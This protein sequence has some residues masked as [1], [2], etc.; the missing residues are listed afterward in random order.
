[1]KK[2]ISI[3]SIT[4]IILFSACNDDYMDRF[5]E[6][7]IGTENFFKSEEDL[8]MFIY[9][10]YNFAGV[11]NY[12]DDGYLTTDN[13]ANTG[14]TELKN[15][16][17]SS[18]P[19]SATITGGWTWSTLRN[20]NLFLENADKADISEDVLNHYKGVA[21]FFRARFYMDKVKR[22]SD[23]PWY[24]QV[25][26]TSNE[27]LLFKGSDSRDMVIQ[28]IFEDYEFAGQNVKAEQ[29][30]G[31]VNKWVVL[32]YKARHALYEGTYRKYHTELEMQS[33]ANTYLQIAIDAAKGIMD[34]GG[35]SI[36]STGNIQ[37]DYASLFNSQNLS[38]NPEIIFANIS[39]DETKNS[40]WWEWMF[41]NYE[42]SPSKD[43]LQAYLMSNG[44]YYSS[45]A[46]PETNSFIEEFE[47]RDPRL[48]QTYAFPGWELINTGTYAQGGGIYKQ[49]LQKNF[50]GY[51]QIKGFVNNT[52]QTVQN[53][54]DF[55]SIR[56]AEM[57][58]IYAEAKAEMGELTQGD[59]DNTI[60][61]LRDRAGMPHLSMNPAVDPIQ[62]ARFPNVNSSQKKEVLEIRRERR[63]EMALEGYRYD[64]LMRWEAGKIL[65]TEPKGLYFPG[66]GKYDMTGDGI[67]DIVLLDLSESIPGAG[68]KE[69]NSLGETLIYYRIGPQDSDASFYISGDNQGYIESVKDRGTF[70]DPKYYYR[71]IPE[72]HTT[73]NPNL[74]QVFGWN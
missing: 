27:E 6:T 71:P 48:N 31:A 52:D 67:E 8:K 65:E 72:T 16:M 73:V 23:V 56:F 62:E 11:N 54:V 39:E 51:H 42:V 53:G 1:M 60:N 63:I 30:L 7:S 41:G 47:N 2:I 14:S 15:I 58:L 26:G 59:L 10:F 64:D 25:I 4:L 12:G 74:T 55:P 34:N 50:T 66:L 46:S 70:V 40:G 28:K 20:I 37:S 18:N 38:S 36:Y 21:R 57:L 45:Q 19:S 68:D 24:D 33:T 44:S 17:L 22:F 32:A 35:F 29:P 43:L 69:V 49:Q 9:N 5:P 3:F 13:A 61:K